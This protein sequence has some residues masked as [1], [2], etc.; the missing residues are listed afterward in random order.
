MRDVREHGISTYGGLPLIL[1]SFFSVSVFLPLP[2][3]LRPLP[4]PL[5]F[6]PLRF[7]SFVIG[8]LRF[9]C[10]FPRCKCCCSSCKC[11]FTTFFLL[12]LAR[13]KLQYFKFFYFRRPAQTRANASRQYVN[14][15]D[16]SRAGGCGNHGKW[17]QLAAPVRA[18]PEDAC[19]GLGCAGGVTR[20][21]CQCVKCTETSQLS[22]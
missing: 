10:L 17:M 16:D 20:F 5:D 3:P 4:L 8:T 12:I 1:I 7:I 2:L 6:F 18:A 21:V 9:L 11:A 19:P 15:N 22:T 13:G 14:S